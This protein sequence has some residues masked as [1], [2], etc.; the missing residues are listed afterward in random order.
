[1]SA[2]GPRTYYIGKL[3]REMKKEQ[4]GDRG[5]QYTVAGGKNFPSSKTAARLA[6][7]FGTTERT[8]RHAAGDRG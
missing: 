2:S 7:Q 8:V 4:G 5:N 6:E 3:Y 1:M